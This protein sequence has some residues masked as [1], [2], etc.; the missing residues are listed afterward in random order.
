MPSP[1]PVNELLDDDAFRNQY[2][3]L[4]RVLAGAKRPVQVKTGKQ[5]TATSLEGEVSSTKSVLR[6]DPNE[7]DEPV[8]Y[9]AQKMIRFQ[10]EHANINAHKHIVEY[11]H[12][13]MKET[14]RPSMCPTAA[15]KDM[16]APSIRMD[17]SQSAVYQAHHSH[18]GY[19]I[20]SHSPVGDLSVHDG[21]FIG[22]IPAI[23][24]VSSMKAK[25]EPLPSSHSLQ[26]KSALDVCLGHMQSE[27]I[28]MQHLNN[29]WSR[30]IDTTCRNLEAEGFQSVGAN[31]LLKNLSLEQQELIREQQRAIEEVQH[32]TCDTEQHVETVQ[33]KSREAFYASLSD[34]CVDK[35]NKATQ[36][37]QAK[38]MSRQAEI[39]GRNRKSDL[40]GSRCHARTL[41]RWATNSVRDG[42]GSSVSALHNN[43]DWGHSM[44]SDEKSKYRPGAAEA[45]VLRAGY[46]EEPQLV[47]QMGKQIATHYP[48]VYPASSHP[49]G[50][51]P[52]SQKSQHEKYRAWEREGRPTLGSLKQD[53]GEKE[54]EGVAVEF[55]RH[56]IALKE[57]LRKQHEANQVEDNMT[58][59]KL[60]EWDR[61]VEVGKAE[62]QRLVQERGELE[63][64]AERV[65]LAREE[66]RKKLKEAKRKDLE[67]LERAQ[68]EEKDRLSE[69]QNALKL[70]NARRDDTVD[71]Q[72]E[73]ER[74]A[75][76][77]LGDVTG[78]VFDRRA[79]KG[80]SEGGDLA[81]RFNSIAQRLPSRRPS[82]RPSRSES[83]LRQTPPSSPDDF[84]GPQYSDLVSAGHFVG[85]CTDDQ[86]APICSSGSLIQWFRPLPFTEGLICLIEQNWLL[87]YP[88][89]C[90]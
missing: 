74:Q 67:A 2:P 81:G 8:A 68:Q 51:M 32:Q 30:D 33:R 21:D 16:C 19:Q 22:H 77:I 71:G 47:E 59:E 86:F 26:Q 46:S 85:R 20:P 87:V 88:D 50:P 4:S 29:E 12:R 79:S 75:T 3:A 61:Q 31:K 40:Q 70:A 54:L 78:P 45:V 73:I 6:K 89:G 62:F 1:S 5:V 23:E 84:S 80:P 53:L 15:R 14:N 76:A 35:K 37:D 25:Q 24:S 56:L 18:T 90:A 41:G 44:K 17:R 65:W 64:E 38:E 28:R 48:K 60:A 27:V 49:T 63:K 11:F 39:L 13:L 9:H 57:K 42:G 34:P 7:K 72:A 36:R 69:L 82:R 10:E 43:L 83:R 66:E 52:L 55:D 58:N